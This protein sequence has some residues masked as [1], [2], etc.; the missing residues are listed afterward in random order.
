MLGALYLV[1]MYSLS[2]L[3]TGGDND[4]PPSHQNIVPGG[5]YVSGNGRSAGRHA[6]VYD[7][8][9]PNETLEWVDLKQMFALDKPS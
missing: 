4:V 6:L 1:I 2:E 5:G 8:N 9:T 7:I 3:I